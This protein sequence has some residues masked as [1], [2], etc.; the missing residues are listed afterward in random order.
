MEEQ[1]VEQ[2]S[3]ATQRP[4]T[5]LRW[6]QVSER[7]ISLKTLLRSLYDLRITNRDPVHSVRLCSFIIQNGMYMAFRCYSVRSLYH[8]SPALSPPWYGFLRRYWV[9]NLRQK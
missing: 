8:M 5:H 6:A 2:Q 3:T 9:R 4:S 7:R 1:K